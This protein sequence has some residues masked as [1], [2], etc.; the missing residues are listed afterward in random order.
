MKK[1]LMIATVFL[2]A[3]TACEAEESVTVLV[4]NGAPA[5]SQLD[6]EQAMNEEENPTYTIQTVYGASPLVS[7]FGSES[8]DI[9]YA[10][11]NLG[12]KLYNDADAPYTFA[13]TVTWG[14]LYLA[15]NTSL[16]SLE[17]LEG[18]TI[19]AFGQNTTPDIVLSSILD[20]IDFEDE[21]QINYVES[22]DSAIATLGEESDS[23]A[24]V[25]EPALSAYEFKT[26]ALNTLDLQEAWL[27]HV[28]D[29]PYPQAGVFVHEDL[30]KEHVD[31]YLDAL[32]ESCRLI[33][34]DYEAAGDMALILEYPFPKAL[35]DSMI[36]RSHIAYEDAFESKESLIGYFEVIK[37]FNPAL[38]GS[39]I[40]DDAFYYDSES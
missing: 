31:A 2:V 5:L 36:P 8:H 27:T 16:E 33:N 14:N 38:I 20:A 29:S 35:M 4:P 7:A 28:S 25:A 15:S 21:P 40:P 26:N 12:A 13:A 10:P 6:I 19:T 23:I 22:V 30:D 39:Q 9:I 3:L 34:N 18:K 24:L 11:T 32:K 1:L 37:S 17:D